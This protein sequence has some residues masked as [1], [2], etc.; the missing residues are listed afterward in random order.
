M[1]LCEPV[2][3][4]SSWSPLASSHVPAPS[5]TH[6][7]IISHTHLHTHT[8]S[9]THAHLLTH[10]WSSSSWSPLA[11]SLASAPSLTYT[12]TRSLTQAHSYTHTGSLTHLL[13]LARSPIYS[14]WLTHSYTHTGSLTHAHSPAHS[15]RLGP[16]GSFRPMGKLYP[17]AWS[18]GNT[19]NLARSSRAEGRCFCQ[20]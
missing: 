3:H 6:T 19:S 11:S 8:R 16:S 10:S 20:Y 13:A 9:L 2:C 7:H 5:L 15:F 18:A 4:S 17:R 1:L 14:P 12:H